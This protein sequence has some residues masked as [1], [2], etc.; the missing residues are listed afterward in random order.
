[1]GRRG[2]RG[3]KITIASLFK[4]RAQE[5]KSRSAQAQSRTK[6]TVVAK[7]TC[8]LA[9]DV[10]FCREFK[11]NT[12][13]K[14][15]RQWQGEEFVTFSQTVAVIPT[16]EDFQNKLQARARGHF[17]SGSNAGP[18]AVVVGTTH[19]GRTF[20]RHGW[21]HRYRQR[22]MILAIQ[23][24]LARRLASGI[25]AYRPKGSHLTA[26][27]EWRNLPTSYRFQRRGDF[28]QCFPSLP[29]WLVE[30]VLRQQCWLSEEVVD[31]MVSSLSPAIVYLPRAEATYITP[32]GCGWT[33]ALPILLT[34]A[35]LVP[36][37]VTFTLSEVVFKPL[38][39]KY[40]KQ[41]RI[42][43]CA[44]DFLLM[45]TSP[46]VVDDAMDFIA[47]TLRVATRESLKLH[48]DKTMD[49]TVDVTKAPINFLRKSLHT[50]SIRTPQKTLNAWAWQLIRFHSTDDFAARAIAILD[51]MTPED[52]GTLRRFRGFL[53]RACGDKSQGAR[54]F[55][56][57]KDLWTTWSKT[58]KGAEA[59][60]EYEYLDIYDQ[61]ETVVR[62][63]AQPLFGKLAQEV[64]AD[65]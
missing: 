32:L 50:R 40:G 21:E 35:P 52:L 12:E 7:G 24:P 44:D 37:L 46:A 9:P 10:A 15:R 42:I 45:G 62:E 1:M 6:S 55:K 51:N 11:I 20:Y 29:D 30:Y 31:S 57:F 8:P 39:N 4:K 64:S 41:L 23:D 25:H 48:P 65:V 26:L 58:R 36:P 27:A 49:C 3:R 17:E 34:G 53:Q 2:S 60:R 43:V 13:S 33:K 47:E 16:T 28:R 18:D 61:G 56:E 63:W 5:R 59:P 54:I 14:E 19:D 38:L 22:L